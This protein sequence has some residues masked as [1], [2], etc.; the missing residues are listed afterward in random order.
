MAS[1]SKWYRNWAVSQLLCDA[2]LGL[3]L[4]YPPADFDIAAARARLQ[5][6][7]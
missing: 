2:L 6:P 5:P 4:G 7:S 3:D 1:D